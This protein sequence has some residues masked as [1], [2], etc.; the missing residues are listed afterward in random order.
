MY[1]AQQIP[2]EDPT[3]RVAD[4][5]FVNNNYAR[6]EIVKASSALSAANTIIDNLTNQGL[7]SS[8]GITTTSDNVFDTLTEPDITEHAAK[9]A[10]DRHYPVALAQ[11]NNPSA[12]DSGK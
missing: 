4:I 12:D 7:L 3:L 1:G 2:G 11:R 8:D 5:T 9:L 6:C 10:L